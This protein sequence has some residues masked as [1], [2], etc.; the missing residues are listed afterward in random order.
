[1]RLPDRA[2]VDADHDIAGPHASFRRRAAWGNVQS[3][4]AGSAVNPDNAVV[5]EAETVLLLEVNDSGDGCRYSQQGQDCG[6]KLKLQ[7]LKHRVRPALTR[8]TS[9]RLRKS[10]RL[11]PAS[12]ARLKQILRYF[13]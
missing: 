7:F 2:A 1:N 5:G 6:R 13:S 11:L 10:A 4:H 3:F 8:D 9:P 12:D